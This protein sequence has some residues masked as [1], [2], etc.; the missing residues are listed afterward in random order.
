M[1]QSRCEDVLREEAHTTGADT[2]GGWGEAVDVFAMQ[3]VALQLL[4]RDAVG[5]CVG[6]LREQADFSDRGCLC[7]F[8]FATEV[9]R[10]DHVLTQG[11]HRISPFVRR[12]VDLRR[13]T[14]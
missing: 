3:E 6:E 5:G 8:A 1:D 13:K 7:P 2:H 4:F 14:S 11:A 9:E 12:V 10:R